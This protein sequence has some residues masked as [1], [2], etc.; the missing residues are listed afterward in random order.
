MFGHVRLKDLT[1]IV[2]S[3]HSKH[4]HEK[5]KKHELGSLKKIN[6]NRTKGAKPGGERTQ[7]RGDK[8][9]SA[10]KGRGKG[11]ERSK[12]KTA[13]MPRGEA[14]GIKWIG[15]R[16]VGNTCRRSGRTWVPPSAYTFWISTVGMKFLFHPPSQVVTVWIK[17]PVWLRWR[18]RTICIEPVMVA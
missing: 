2:P 14:G 5:V 7:S 17:C 18:L 8:G 13:D 11:R 15:L 6:Q 1:F 16:L 12:S 9:R 4:L 3:V 10:S